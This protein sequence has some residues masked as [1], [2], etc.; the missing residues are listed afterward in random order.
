MAAAIRLSQ[1][2]SCS[3]V[4]YANAQGMKGIGGGS[5][6]GALISNSPLHILVPLPLASFRKVSYSMI[7]STLANTIPGRVRPRFFAALALM[8]NSNFVGS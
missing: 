8:I 5:L 7:S 2:H 6:Q 1:Q 4:R 3:F